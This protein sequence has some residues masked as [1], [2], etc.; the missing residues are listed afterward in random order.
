MSSLLI[1]ISTSSFMEISSGF[2]PG[3]P[4]KVKPAKIPLGWGKGSLKSAVVMVFG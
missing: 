3:D 2:T 1:P 4:F